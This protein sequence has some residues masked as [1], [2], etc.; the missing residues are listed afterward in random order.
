MTSQSGS[1]REKKVKHRLADGTV[2]VYSYPRDK[3]AAEPRD[4]ESVGALIL[5][6][7]RSPEW[8]ALSESSRR[9]YTLYLKPLADMAHKPVRSLNRRQLLTIRDAIA[10]A[11]G[12]GAAN[13]FM[14]STAAMLKWA[15]RRDWIEY[16]PIR[17]E[18]MLK[19]GHHPTWT[20]A[21]TD[22]AEATLP[23]HLA[24]VVTLARYT[25]QRRTD[26][27]TMLWSAYDGQSVRVR[28]AKTGAELTIPCHPNLKAALDA[29][30]R[31]AATI[32]TDATGRPWAPDKFS[33]AIRAAL[34]RIGFP[35]GY[36]IHGV[37]KQAAVALAEAGCSTHEI[38]AIT[39]HKTLAMVELYTRGVSQERL[40]TA[41]IVRLSEHSGK[42]K[43]GGGKGG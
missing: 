20:V 21:Q 17:D 22:L 16:S 4:A 7:Q 1:S 11:R 3:P 27:V 29:W 26:L 5:A 9:V 37:R 33:N 18:R 30:P 14:F 40:A 31:T 2:K 13:A 43:T 36:G 39:G 25:A 8:R 19:G 41:A 12:T 15:V 6:Y 42:R 38:G 28:Q 24:R 32:L 23:S 10:T 35:P 34:P